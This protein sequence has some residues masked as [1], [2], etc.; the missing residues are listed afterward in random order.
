M[1]KLAF[2]FALTSAAAMAQGADPPSRVARLNYL[3]GSV[4]F[5]PASVEDW[6]GA[7]LNYPL[8]TGDHLWTDP[9]AQTELHIGS[10][11]IRMNS[12]TALAILNLDDRIVQLSL[13][14]GALN[15][16]IRNLGPEE[17]Y[18]VDTPN[19]ALVLLRP[20]DYHIE[21]PAGPDPDRPVTVVTPRGGEVEVT[22]GGVA[23]TVHPGQTARVS[24]TDSVNQEV[25]AALPPDGFDRWCEV[26]ERREESSVSAAYVPRDMIGYEDLDEYGRWRLVEPYGWVWSPTNVEAGWA[27]YHFGRWAW[28]DPWGW[29]WIDEAPWGFAPFHYGRWAFVGGGWFWVP[30]R[31]VVGVRPVYAPAL[32]AF[33]GGPRFGVS[34]AVGGGVGL[35]AW[36]PLGPGEVYRPAYRVSDAYVRNVNIVHVTNVTVINNVNATNVRYVNQSVPGAVMAVPHEAFVSARPVAAVAVRVDAREVAQAPVTGSTAAIPPRR[37]SVVSGPVRT[38]VPAN[39]MER[40]VVVKSAP[41]PPPVSFAAKQQALQANQGRPLDT[42]TM[43]TLRATNPPRAPTVRP[44][45]PAP[46]NSPP[47]RNDRPVSAAPP[48]R[49]V[50]TPERT[51]ETPPAARK[52]EPPV[53]RKASPPANDKGNKPAKKGTRR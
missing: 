42:T 32:V 30:G 27:P 12:E 29:T 7:S 25:G 44:A 5:R 38:S 36:F 52:E 53:E 8:T 17:S 4:S 6:T 15:V 24:G 48:S 3:S 13:T 40:P 11:A 50:Q 19:V 23:F 33:V 16:H 49:T 18:E 31:L 21:V 46:R 22:G 2:L 43:N 20:G 9:G 28:V 26:R 35:A 47:P 34:V 10:T 37:E 1:R 41:P 51:V 39:R 45:V 14:G